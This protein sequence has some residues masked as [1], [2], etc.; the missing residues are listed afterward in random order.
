MARHSARLVAIVGAVVF[1]ALA[2]PSIAKTILFDGKILTVDESFSIAEAIAIDGDTIVAVG[3]NEEILSGHSGPEV[4]RIDLRGKTVIPGLIDGHFHL[5]RGAEFWQSEVRLEGVT[6]RA[7]ALEAIRQRA[8]SAGPGTWIVTLGGW[9]ERQFVGDA[10]PFG[11][12]E[13]DAVA[14]DNAVFLQVGYS[15]GYA[16]TTA[17]RLAGVA[18]SLKSEEK[19]AVERSLNGEATGLVNGIARIGAIRRALGRGGSDR[20]RGIRAMM[21]TLNGVGLTAVYDPGGFGLKPE[22][23]TTLRSFIQSG[24]STLRVYRSLW[25]ET[26]SLAVVSET[27]NTI[28]RASTFSGDD[29]YDVVAIGETVYSPLHDNFRMPIKP[30]GDERVAIGAILRAAAEAKLQYHIHA[31]ERDSLEIYLQEAELI[32]KD[33]DLVPLRWTFAHAWELIE[34]QINRMRRLGIAIALQS[35]SSFD[36]ARIRVAGEAG[37]HM[38]PIRTVQASGLVW[39]LGTDATVVGQVNPFITLGW[40]VT[41]TMPGGKI[42]NKEPISREQALIAHTRSNAYLAFRENRIGSLQPGKLADLVVLDQDY[43]TIAASKI[44][45]IRPLATMLGGKFVYGNLK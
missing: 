44:W 11:R 12:E 23:Y 24:Q 30:N 40:A 21:A 31:I 43:L 4:E 20:E 8:N 9:S 29:M 39:G 25:L 5:L 2:S 14:P 17:L 37:Y 13:L 27:I 38:P 22:D 45:K 1:A 15:R 3:R 10:R 28:G 19:D 18:T 35:G 26:P 42:T 36:D 6:S 32:A 16:N 7:E 41:G 33:Y 34:D